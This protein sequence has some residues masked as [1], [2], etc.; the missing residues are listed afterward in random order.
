MNLSIRVSVLS[1]IP[2]IMFV[3]FMFG[4]WL[5]KRSSVHLRS[6]LYFFSLAACLTFSALFLAHLEGAF[7]KNGVPIGWFG[8]SIMKALTIFLDLSGEFTIVSFVSFLIIAPQCMAYVLS[9]LYGYADNNFQFKNV[10]L[11]LFYIFVKSL[12]SFSGVT[13]VL[14]PFVS[15]EGWTGWKTDALWK[16]IGVTELSSLFIVYAFG[17]SLAVLYKDEIVRRV[18]K[19]IPSPVRFLIRNVHECL[20]RH[21]Q[22]KSRTAIGECWAKGVCQHSAGVSTCLRP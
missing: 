19:M 15:W 8:R 10:L 22:P 13:I 4:T 5:G 1:L 17:M 3:L 9:G 16:T 18:I 12:V 20:T 14:I 7:D 11:G 6:I 21:L 2:M